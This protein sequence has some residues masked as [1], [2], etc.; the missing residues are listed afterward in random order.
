MRYYPVMLD[1]TD[2]KCV[3]IGG[4]AVG[5]RKV[6][7]L[8]ECGAR[9]TVISP[10]AHDSLVDL[11]AQGEIILH[12]RGY[13]SADLDGAFLLIG[14]TD[15]ADL[16]EKIS[17]DAHQNNLLCNIADRPGDCNFIL[18]SIVN[19]K[20]LVI[21]ISTCGQSPAFAKKIRQDLQC[22]FGA[23]YGVFL[24]L[25]GAV[26]KKLL[27]QSHAP[28]EHKGLFNRLIGN[29]LLDLLA[30]RDEGGADALLE[31]VLG[32]GYSIRELVGGLN[33]RFECTEAE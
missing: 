9:V 26:R 28:E 20:D 31:Q 2:K 25:M 13:K 18:P 21:A 32:A 8:L 17:R 1:V 15:D 29:G 14:A 22:M 33:D 5:A 30:A 24:E 6:K 16:N 3:V 19:Q 7:T 11:A 4:G 12:A 23:E 27:A 10:Q